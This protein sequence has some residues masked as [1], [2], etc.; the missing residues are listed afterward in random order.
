VTNPLRSARGA[1]ALAAPLALFLACPARAAELQPEIR[2]VPAY[3]SGDFGTGI[4]T[5]MSYVP[6]ILILGSPRQEFRLTLPYL[7]VTTSQPVT[8]VG[9]EII[10]RGSGGRT[11]E[12]GLGDVVAQE[13]YFFVE[14]GKRRPWISGLFRI[15]AP[16]ADETRGLGTG[17][18][19]Y[20]PGASFIQPLGD[21][22]S[23]LGEAMYVVRG[24]PRGADFRNTWWLSGG[25]QRKLWG[26]SSANF[27]YERLQ[28]VLPGRP[29]LVDLIVGFDHGFARRLTLRTS[30]FV[31]LSDTAEDYGLSAGISLR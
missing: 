10:P 19:D 6:I 20:G 16:T 18:W 28:S 22:W 1:A 15:K 12:S 9:S 5:E 31:G 8:F 13:E 4:S 14:G 21:R 25:L 29:D 24:D 11:T 27:Y 2:F 23:L 7:S 26:A 3:F 30:V 17:E